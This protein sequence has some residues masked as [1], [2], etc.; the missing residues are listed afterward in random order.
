MASEK[1]EPSEGWPIRS[2]EP[3]VI[4]VAQNQ[5]E[6]LYWFTYRFRNLFAEESDI[7]ADREQA[8]RER[9]YELWQDGRPDGKAFEY[10]L[11][12]EAEISAAAD[13][14]IT[15]AETR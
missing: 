5:D 4:T 13:K 1:L 12:A 9:A 7:G 6:L 3:G 8:I 10:W 14:R 2:Q 15:G 11:R